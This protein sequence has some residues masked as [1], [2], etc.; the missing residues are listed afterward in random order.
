[1]SLAKEYNQATEQGDTLRQKV[2]EAEMKKAQESIAYFK[3][4]IWSLKKICQDT[5]A[6][7]TKKEIARVG[8][9]L[10]RKD[11]PKY[12]LAS[13]VRLPFP[14]DEAFDSEEHFLRTFEKVVYSAG[15]DIEMVWDKYLPLCIHYDHDPWVEAEI[16]G[17]HDWKLA[18]KCFLN[19]FTTLH[20]TRESATMVFA[21][22]M[23][24]IETV[25]QYNARFLR[26]VNDADLNASDPM[27]A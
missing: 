5:E 12:Q 22:V 16:K 7:A 13:S 15:M 6:T 25:T 9:T 27:L 1:M 19:K 21:M 8:L 24:D 10:T 23:R 18:R 20:C 4:S 11:L 17:C 2:I 26:V 3:K 14:N